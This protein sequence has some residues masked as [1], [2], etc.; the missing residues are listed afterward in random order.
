VC[1]AFYWLPCPKVRFLDNFSGGR[2]GAATTE[3]LLA[4]GYS[5]IFLYRERSLRPF[6]WRCQGDV[7]DLLTVD[8]QG[9][10]AGG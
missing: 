10:L 8:S 3:A 6:Q 7:V 5:V 4:H 1:W 9:N 2:R